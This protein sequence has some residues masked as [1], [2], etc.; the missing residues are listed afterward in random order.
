M[1]NIESYNS[2]Y[3]LA[4]YKIG[5]VY[6]FY[7]QSSVKGNPAEEEMIKKYAHVLES[8]IEEEEDAIKPVKSNFEDSS[9]S[10][11]LDRF[12]AVVIDKVKSNDKSYITVMFCNRCNG[13]SE[14]YTKKYAVNYGCATDGK[15]LMSATTH[16]RFNKN[17]GTVSG[18]TRSVDTNKVSGVTRANPLSAKNIRK[19]RV[20]GVTR[21]VEE[22]RVS[23][24][25]RVISSDNESQKT[26][27]VSGV[28][29]AK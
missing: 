3:A 10:V 13:K 19:N 28:T 11:K 4:Y 17:V 5:Q 20:S 14:Y 24:V 6:S 26:S 29:R 22:K 15:E 8:L 2:S 23:G 7:G 25:T 12:Y 27:R 16:L 1:R 18:V 9:C 21:V